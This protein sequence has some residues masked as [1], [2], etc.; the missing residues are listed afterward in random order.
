MHCE[1]LG[2]DGRQIRSVLSVFEKPPLLEE[3]KLKVESRELFKDINDLV[4]WV[5]IKAIVNKCI[6]LTQK[7]K[8]KKDES[9]LGLDVQLK[10]QSM[11]ENGN[12]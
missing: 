1:Q 3:S 12:F 8:I 10:I 4:D 11:F 2:E 9:D 7:V 6:E 5:D